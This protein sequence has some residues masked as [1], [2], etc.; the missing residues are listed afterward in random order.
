MWRIAFEI[1]WIFLTVYIIM[2]TEWYWAFPIILIGV[3]I[4]LLFDKMGME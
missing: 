1:F 2:S 3:G 4:E